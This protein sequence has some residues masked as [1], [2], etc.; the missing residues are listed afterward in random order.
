[1][2]I[3]EIQLDSD[4]SLWE[5]LIDS[6]SEYVETYLEEV[7]KDTDNFLL[8][9]DEAYS[10]ESIEEHISALNELLIEVKKY[11]NSGSQTYKIL[12]HLL[13]YFNQLR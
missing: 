1:M 13:K 8:L 10:P 6:V 9:C 2:K 3:T 5:R 7:Q 12:E 11:F 4:L